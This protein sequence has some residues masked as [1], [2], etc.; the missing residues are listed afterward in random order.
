LWEAFLLQMD[1]FDR[2]LE[3][4]LRRKLDAVVRSPVPPRRVRPGPTRFGSGGRV[5]AT[6]KRMGGF[7]IDLRPDLLVFVEHS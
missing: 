7:S 1:D 6:T 3:F 5:D 2:L 4:Q